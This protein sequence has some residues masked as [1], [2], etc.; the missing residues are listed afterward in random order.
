MQAM[1]Q[2]QLPSGL[3]P[4]T[5]VRADEARRIGAVWMGDFMVISPFVMGGCGPAGR[6]CAPAA[7]GFEGRPG[8]DAVADARTCDARPDAGDATAAAVE[9]VHA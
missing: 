5:A 9:L 3:T 6:G 8:S 2:P 7:P 4:E 1:G